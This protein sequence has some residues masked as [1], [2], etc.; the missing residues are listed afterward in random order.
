LNFILA[1]LALGAGTAIVVGCSSSSA[2]SAF[3][4]ETPPKD[5]PNAFGGNPTLPTTDAASPKPPTY[6]GN[7]LCQVKPGSCMPDDDGYRRTANTEEC[8]KPPPGAG[9]AATMD[10]YEGSGCRIARVENGIA[11]TCSTKTLAAAG[12]GA[13]CDLGQDCAPGFDCVAGEKG[14]K[15]C[16]HYCCSGTCK[17]QM[18]K[19][20]GATFCDVQSLV[21]VNVKAPVCMPLKHCTLLGTNECTQYE[22]CAVV[23]ESGDTGCVT[24]GEKQV[25]GSCDEDHCAATLTCLGQPG[26]RKCYKLCKV[27]SSE[28]GPA[29][30]CTTSTVFKDPEFGICQKP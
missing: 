9:D 12:D 25:G 2:D 23:T 14:A 20:G 30:I 24:V 11:P 26:S 1:A 4:S 8:A 10:P 3:G 27:N 17:G 18:S 28:C 21:D 5:D 13:S 22:S 29:Q 7:P 16:R 19:N 15:A 6:R